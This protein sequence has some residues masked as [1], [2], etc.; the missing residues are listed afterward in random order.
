[1][2]HFRVWLKKLV[3]RQMRDGHTE[4]AVVS[5]SAEKGDGPGSIPAHAGVL[6]GVKTWL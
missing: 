3:R 4:S 2:G 5:A 1:M 6:V